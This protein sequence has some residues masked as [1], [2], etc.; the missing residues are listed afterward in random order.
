MKK[1]IVVGAIIS[2]C[3]VMFGGLSIYFVVRMANKATYKR[4]TQ[5]LVVETFG[6]LKQT[7]SGG[8]QQSLNAFEQLKQDTADAA[9]EL[10]NR[11]AP[12]GAE[13]LK[14]NA[15]QLI[16]V[17]SGIADRGI[18]F[19]TYIVKTDSIVK[20]WSAGIKKASASSDPIAKLKEFQSATTAAA[21]S[22]KKLD[23]PGH[24]V[25][26]HLQLTGVL[27]DMSAKLGE[28]VDAANAKDTA[29]LQAISNDWDRLSTQFGDLS[30]SI[31]DRIADDIM[32][33][34]DRRKMERLARKIDNS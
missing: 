14:I 6:A 13:E 9:D 2:A 33:P 5:K 32:T 19:F 8:P 28:M 31:G 18:L 20:T 27:D 15:V 12:S 16:D 30:G 23:P 17:A 21:D 26:F 24:L 25:S 22:L 29:R 7:R 34:E 3:V 4:Q 11:P 10:Q 1:W